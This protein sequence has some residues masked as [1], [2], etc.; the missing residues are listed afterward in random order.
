METY[1]SGD[2]S[3]GD[4]LGRGIEEIE[5][6]RLYDLGDNFRTDTET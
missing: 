4:S 1:R 5:C 2:I 3:T 6:R